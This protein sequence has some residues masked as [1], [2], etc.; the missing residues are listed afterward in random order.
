MGSCLSGGSRDIVCSVTVDLVGGALL[1]YGGEEIR[2]KLVQH[3]SVLRTQVSI[4]PRRAFI[5][6]NC[7][8]RGDLV[9][10]CHWYGHGRQ[11]GSGAG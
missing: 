2:L 9:C 10:V 11:Q 5:F 1:K 4:S 3:S 7:I 6:A 8:L